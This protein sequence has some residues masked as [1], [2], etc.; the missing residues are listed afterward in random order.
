MCFN[1]QQGVMRQFSGWGVIDASVGKAD[2]GEVQYTYEV[3]T[4]GGANRFPGPTRVKLTSTRRQVLC[5]H[6]CPSF[7]LLALGLS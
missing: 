3:T 4:R 7:K 2:T 1:A 5:F 6:V